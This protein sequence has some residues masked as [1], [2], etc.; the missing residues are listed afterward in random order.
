MEGYRCRPRVPLCE[1][2]RGRSGNSPLKDFKEC[3]NG[4][5]DIAKDIDA[6]VGLSRLLNMT[7]RDRLRESCGNTWASLLNRPFTWNLFVH[8][9]HHRPEA[10]LLDGPKPGLHDVVMVIG[11]QKMSE[12]SSAESQE[13]MGS[14]GGHPVGEP[15]RNHDARLLTTMHHG[16]T[17]HVRPQRRSDWPSVIRRPARSATNQ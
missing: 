14:A 3:M 2:S 1:A 15:L 9:M 11:F 4:C 10:G 12:I 8:S 13:R 16:L 7:S 6:T 5:T 17:W